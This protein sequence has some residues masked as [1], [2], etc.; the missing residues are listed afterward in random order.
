MNEDYTNLIYDNDETVKHQIVYNPIEWVNN[1]IQ[2]NTGDINDNNGSDDDDDD[3]NKVLAKDADYYLDANNWPYI[4]N[5]C[6][7]GFIS[8]FLLNRY[9]IISGG[10]HTKDFGFNVAQPGN[11]LKC[12]DLKT[13]KWKI[14][15]FKYTNNVDKVV[16][17]D[18]NMELKHVSGE[19]L[20]LDNIDGNKR[21]HIMGGR[22]YNNDMKCN[23]YIC[24][25]YF[26]WKYERLVWIAFEKNTKNKSC[27]LPK[28]PKEVIKLILEFLK[29]TSLDQLIKF[30]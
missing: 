7:D 24:I 10:S 28:L 29:T 1:V 4:N 18:N 21:I 16:G 11:T 26:E 8:Q 6:F 27:L 23:F 14:F 5:T 22:R 30:I 15:A 17:K 12:F 9:L 3:N 20:F 2:H 25:N 13:K 19:S